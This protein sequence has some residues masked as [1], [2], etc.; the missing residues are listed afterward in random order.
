MSQTGEQLKLVG[1][2]RAAENRA[3]EL[4]HAKQLAAWI[5]EQDDRPITVEDLRDFCMVHK[6]PWKLGNAAGSIF[7]GPE[8]ECCGFKA[9][10]HPSAHGRM[11]RTW[12]LRK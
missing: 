10:T 1:M 12:R 11:I 9:A 5:A 2:T 7:K 6:M 4:L 3:E 8:W